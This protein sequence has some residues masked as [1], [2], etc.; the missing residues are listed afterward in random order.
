L[1]VRGEVIGNKGIGGKFDDE[2]DTSFLN[3]S[4]SA[5]ARRALLQRRS[6]TNPANKPTPPRTRGFDAMAAVV[7]EEDTGSMHFHY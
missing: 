3:A 5:S 4:F 7:G 6:M 1:T 2:L